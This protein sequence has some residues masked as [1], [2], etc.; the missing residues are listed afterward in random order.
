WT[1][2]FPAGV[3]GTASGTLNPGS[4]SAT[5]TTAITNNTNA[6]QTV[7]YTFT[8]SSNGCPGSPVTTQVVVQPVATVGPFSPITVCPGA[9]ITPP[10]FV[11]N[12]NG[13]TFN[14]VSSNPAGIGSPPNGSGQMSPWTAPANN[15]NTT[16]SSNIAV[17]PTYNNCQGTTASFVITINPTPTITNNNLS[18]SICSGANTTAVNWTSNL[19]GTTYA[20]E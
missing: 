19:A 2:T 15:S 11:S 17:T 8:P 5:L 3:T 13:A 12:P 9:T 14:W 7:T 10:A 4:S 6:P 16:V 18:Q 20:W 1:A